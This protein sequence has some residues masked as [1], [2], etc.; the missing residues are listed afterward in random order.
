MFQKFLL[1]KGIKVE[2]DKLKK[3]TVEELQEELRKNKRKT[4]DIRPYYSKV[5]EEYKYVT[6]KVESFLNEKISIEEI[7]ILKKDMIKKCP[8]I[9][10]PWKAKKSYK[11]KNKLKEVDPRKLV[12]ELSDVEREKL[13][14]MLMREN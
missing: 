13:I 11:R 10:E 8:T 9:V 6:D 5:L 2:R 4:D 14:E 12:K 7:I 3:L 1:I